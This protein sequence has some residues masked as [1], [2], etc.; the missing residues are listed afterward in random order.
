MPPVPYHPS[1]VRDRLSLD[2]FDRMGLNIVVDSLRK[3]REPPEPM[4]RALIDPN[5]CQKC[6]PCLVEMNCEM[7][8][9][10][11]ESEED[12]PWV[13][14]YRCSGCL[15]CKIVCQHGAVIEITQP[16]TGGGK[17]GW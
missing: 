4:K 9:A 1:D 15:K 7:H 14:F 12:G 6:H 5:R 16:C 2:M 8:A 11:R 3:K 17:L 10:F 13:D